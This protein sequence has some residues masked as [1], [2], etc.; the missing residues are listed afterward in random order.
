VVTPSP[1]IVLSAQPT[2]EPTPIPAVVATAPPVPFEPLSVSAPDCNR[3]LIKTIEALDEHTVRFSLCAPDPAFLSKIAFPTFGIQPKEW[4]E[5]TGGGGADSL[6]LRQPVGTGPYTV[7]E[8]IAGE[9]LVFRAFDG[10]WGNQPALASTLVFRWDSD[11]GQRLLELQ[12]GTVDGIDDLNPTDFSA[13]QENPD[14]VLVPRP[15][16]NT[17]FIGINNNFPPFDQENVRRAFA[18]ALDRQR[19]LEVVFPEG[20]EVARFFTP[21]SIPYACSGDAW[22]EFDPKMARQLLS[23]AGVGAGFRTELYYRDAPR[24]Y[25]PQPFQT[26]KE[27]QA[28]LQQNLGIQVM[29]RKADPATYFEQLDAGL[30]PGLY[31]SGWGA[32][33]PDI[34]NFLDTHFGAASSLQFG[35]PYSDLVDLLRQGAQETDPV[36]RQAAYQAA[37]NAIRQRIPVIP[38]AHGGWVSIDSSAVAFHK[39]VQGAHANPLGV[40]TFAVMAY[41]GRD[42]LTWM[43]KAEPL[44]LY[45]ADETDVETL[46]AC[47]QVTETLYRYEL[48]SAAVT[49]GLAEVCTPS[50]D[51]TNWTCTLRKGVQFQDASLLDANDVVMSFWVQWDAG[52]PLHKGRTGRFDYFH[53]FFGEF[54]STPSP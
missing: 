31:L 25:L 54:L 34:T 19:L 53:D 18:L 27:I 29:L 23:E 39:D 50:P 32:D 45:C 17:S 20:Y 24:G 21:C 46:R 16:L 8:W 7:Q 52:H 26:A 30:I 41:P 43:Q 42:Q 6:L 2:P 14:L 9:K 44:S 13:V 51:L 49:P 12:T 35:N 37:N 15:A 38:L 5:Q 28:Q 36:T 3:G 4:L 11:P 10:Y 48:G 1:E 33:Y 22:Y 40:E 47:S